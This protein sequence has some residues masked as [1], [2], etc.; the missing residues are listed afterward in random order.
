MFGKLRGLS[1]EYHGD[2]ERIESIDRSTQSTRK[3]T[4]RGFSIERLLLIVD[5]KDGPVMACPAL[6]KRP[7]GCEDRYPRSRSLLQLLQQGT[8]D[9]VTIARVATTHAMSANK[10]R[11]V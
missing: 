11:A 5:L 4:C 6:V 3:Y 8:I 2:P 1:D 10:R 7:A 9:R